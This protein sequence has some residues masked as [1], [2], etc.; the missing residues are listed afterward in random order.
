MHKNYLIL[1]SKM[2]K[3]PVILELS[4]PWSGFVYRYLFPNFVGEPPSFECTGYQWLRFVF[5][6]PTL[7]IPNV[8]LPR[9]LFA[10][11]SHILTY[12]D[13]VRNL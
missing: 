10:T 1:V 6:A 7:D 9:V 2:P 11:H 5:R 8:F 13:P 4:T 3:N 12:T